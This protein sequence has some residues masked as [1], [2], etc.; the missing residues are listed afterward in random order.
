MTILYE[1][2]ELIKPER[3][4][5]FRNDILNLD[6]ILTKTVSKG[7]FIKN[8]TLTLKMKTGEEIVYKWVWEKEMAVIFKK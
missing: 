8:S 6:N 2:K 3:K 4:I 7:I 1:L 5:K